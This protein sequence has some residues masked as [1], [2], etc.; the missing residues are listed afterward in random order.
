[1]VFR[2][3]YMNLTTLSMTPE[4]ELGSGGNLYFSTSRI[5]WIRPADRKSI[6]CVR[7]TYD[8]Y[9]YREDDKDIQW[10]FR[11]TTEDYNK[12]KQMYL[13]EEASV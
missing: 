7:R 2:I 12:L 5:P 6:I 4:P 10:T 11:C 9:I 3:G 13:E 8:V 1:M